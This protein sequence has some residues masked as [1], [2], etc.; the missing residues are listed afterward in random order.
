MI[1][2]SWFCVN[3]KRLQS[4]CWLLAALAVTGIFTSIRAA[5][6][7]DWLASAKQV[8]LGQFGSGSAAVAVGE[9]TE[10]NVD[11]TGKF[12]WT[13]RRAMRVLDVRS[14]EPYLQVTGY[15]SNDVS[16]ISMQ[17]WTVSPSGRIVQAEKKNIATAAAFPNFVL[18]SDDRVKILNIPGSEQGSLVGTEVIRTGKLPLNGERFGL[19]GRL[20]VRLAELHVS[21]PAGSFRWFLNFPERVE[22]VNQSANAA[23]FRVT[24]RPALPRETDAPPFDSLAA[25][26]FIN[27]DAKGAAPVQTWEDAG[28]IIHPLLSAADKPAPAVT[29]QV[30]DLSAGKPDLLAKLN[31]A[32]SFVSRQVRY[33]AVEIGVGGFTPH[34]AADVYQ[35]RYGDCKDKATLLLTMLNHIG[36]R[37]YPAL[38][39]TRG[40][41]EANPK[42]PTL[43]TFDHM[44][45]ALPVPAE[46]QGAVSKFSSF[47][48]ESSILWIDPTSEI[49]PL[50][51]LPE[52]DQGVYALVT[53]PDHGELRRIP[54]MQAE[55]NGIDYRAELNLSADGNGT[56]TV[57]EKYRGAADA[58]RHYTYRNLSQIEL[59]RRFEERVTRYA[60]QAVFRGVN[61]TG[62][63]DFAAPIVEKFTFAGNF[64]NASTGD[65]WYFQPLFLSGLSVPEISPGPR[66]L[67]MDLGVPD[68]VRGE[69]RVQLPAGMTVAD[70]PRDASLQTEFGSLEVKYTVKENV[71]T[72]S[73]TVSFSASRIPVEKFELFRQFVNDIRRAEQ[74]RLQAV[75]AR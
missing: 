43:A 70:V 62:I 22:V 17:A 21:V 15:E 42:I 30:E 54:E 46:L 74:V 56:A 65:S 41:I 14:A 20:P 25:T 9:W 58:T 24:N 31:A 51:Q 32:Y 49:D 50:G 60:N 18:Y 7:P 69:Y 12:I 36:L 45:V 2:K 71:V 44:I 6:I 61:V 13:E 48:P 59:R 75:K 8:D 37:G 67:P 57:E 34:A 64:V 5:S 68:H 72:T 10:F 63:E 29:K 28:K 23:F 73:E 11:A 53:Y 38:V 4:V 55:T 66:V 1:R 33:V 47:D 52:M 27:Y 26:V 19:E 16:V 3:S 35:N 39:G 40:D